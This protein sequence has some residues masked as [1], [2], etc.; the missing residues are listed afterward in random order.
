MVFVV[1]IFDFYAAGKFVG[2]GSYGAL[3]KACGV[4]FVL[5]V[6]ENLLHEVLE[7]DHTGGSS[8][9]VDDDGYGA[10]FGQEAA[11]HLVGHEG[12]RGVDHG[13]EMFAPVAF[14]LEQLADVDIAEHVVDIL[15]VYYDF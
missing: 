4:V 13:F 2:V 6:A 9:L 10:L 5:N 1:E 3:Y 12:L 14:G 15:A 11:H 8:E 7:G